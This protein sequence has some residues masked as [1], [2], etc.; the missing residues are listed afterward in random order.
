VERLR[1]GISTDDWKSR[2]Q[3]MVATLEA[4]TA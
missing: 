2:V 3:R 1:G 4:G